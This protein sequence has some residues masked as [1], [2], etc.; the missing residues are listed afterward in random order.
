M[1]EKSKRVGEKK[2]WERKRGLGKLHSG[3]LKGPETRRAQEMITACSD[4]CKSNSQ[5]AGRLIT[6]VPFW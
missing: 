6:V 3:N 5:Q 4:L 2:G 1:A